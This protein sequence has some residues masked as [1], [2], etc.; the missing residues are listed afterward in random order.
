MSSVLGSGHCD[1]CG[2]NCQDC[3]MDDYR[4]LIGVLQELADA[5]NDACLDHSCDHWSEP[6]SECRVAKLLHRYNNGRKAQ[7]HDD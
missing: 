5:M 2:I 4:V 7:A 3:T 1:R 6:C